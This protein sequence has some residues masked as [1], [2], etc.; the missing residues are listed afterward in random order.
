M[1]RFEGNF[2]VRELAPAL[3]QRRQAAA[4][5]RSCAIENKR[6][7]NPKKKHENISP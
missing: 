5:H 3:K 4:L 6:G 2:G 1:Y 7:T